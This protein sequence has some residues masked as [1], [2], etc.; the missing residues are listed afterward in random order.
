MD[1]YATVQITS[2]NLGYWFVGIYGF[3]GCSF[4]LTQNPVQTVCPNECS[5]R[6]TCSPPTCTC[7]PGYSGD[8]CETRNKNIFK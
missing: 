8:A 5:H 2:P 1:R 4:T 7:A 6:G 3:S